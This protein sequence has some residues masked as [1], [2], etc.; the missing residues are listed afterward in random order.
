MVCKWRV[1]FFGGAQ[2]EWFLMVLKWSCWNWSV[3]APSRSTPSA[4]Q[5]RALPLTTTHLQYDL[6]TFIDTRIWALIAMVIWC[7]QTIGLAETR[8]QINELCDTICHWAVSC[9]PFSGDTFIR[10]SKMTFTRG[11]QRFRGCDWVVFCYMCAKAF[12][13][14][15]MRLVT[16]E[17]LCHGEYNNLWHSM[18][19]A[20]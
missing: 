8:E 10:G 5:Q 19:C 1:F 4:Y 11:V 14:Q 20:C 17:W 18:L 7:Q 9:L 15:R 16:V 13:D 3:W 6:L 2:M 12:V